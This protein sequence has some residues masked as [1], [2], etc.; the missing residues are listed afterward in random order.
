MNSFGRLVL[1][2]KGKMSTLLANKAAIVFLLSKLGRIL[3]PEV[4]VRLLWFFGRG[5]V[6]IFLEVLLFVGWTSA[7]FVIFALDFEVGFF[8]KLRQRV[9]CVQ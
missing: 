4:S 5:F 2:I 8:Y 6:E 3:F 7:L 1:A 9:L